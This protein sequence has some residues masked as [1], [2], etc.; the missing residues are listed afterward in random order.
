M[1]DRGKAVGENQFHK[2][3]TISSKQRDLADSISLIWTQESF[4]ICN[5]GSDQQIASKAGACQPTLWLI[6]G[7][8]P[9]IRHS[10]SCAL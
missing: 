1:N 2:L 6:K 9:A 3:L 10:H 7:K 8:E 5:S 4:W